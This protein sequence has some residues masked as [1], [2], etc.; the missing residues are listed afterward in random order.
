[1]R[2]RVEKGIFNLQIN[3]FQKVDMRERKGI[4]GE[5]GSIWSMFNII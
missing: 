5:G 3:M 2:K 4:K 1:M